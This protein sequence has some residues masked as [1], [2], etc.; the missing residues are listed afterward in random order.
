LS[1]FFP[2][3]GEICETF[4]QRSM[5]ERRRYY[6][7][8][9]RMAAHYVYD[10]MQA[11]TDY[12]PKRQP[13]VQLPESPEV[14]WLEQ[15]KLLVIKTQD[16]HAVV[17]ANKGGTFKVATP[18]GP[19]ESDTGLI[20]KMS[21]GKVVVTHVVDNAAQVELDQTNRRI[22][23]KGKFQK[24]SAPLPTPFKQIIF[25]VLLLTIGRF[26][27]NLVR[28]MLQKILITGKNVQPMRFTRTLEFGDD[29]I[30]V[31]DEVKMLKEEK[32]TFT[33][34]AAGSDATSIY[35]ANSNV[36]QDSV[37]TPWKWFT[38]DVSKLNK[39]RR[40]QL[41]RKIAVQKREES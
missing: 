19:L 17:A 6:N 26:D 8:D 28:S 3:A 11:W 20:G 30:S 1:K 38:K 14:T 9:D 25:R 16:Y 33:D 21:D 27:A 29:Q 2:K 37:L 40:L 34:L 13:I 4:L 35:V 36:Y 12:N 7:D 22:T 32:R 23:I 15:C 5:P 24:R 41:R 10:W 39:E 18:S 31:I